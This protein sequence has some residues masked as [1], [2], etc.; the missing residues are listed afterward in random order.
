MQLCVDIN[1]D[2]LMDQQIAEVMED[3]Y[4]WLAIAYANP[5][6]GSDLTDKLDNISVYIM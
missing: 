5:Q 6:G 2:I 3:M 4:T 1:I